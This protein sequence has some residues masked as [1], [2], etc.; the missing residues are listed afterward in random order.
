[1]SHRTLSN[2]FP[3]LASYC[4]NQSSLP[5]QQLSWEKGAYICRSGETMDQLIFLCR[6]EARV[7]MTLYSGSDVLFRIYQP[8]ELFGDVEFFADTSASISVRCMSSCMAYAMP[9]EQLRRER[10]SHPD[11][12]FA[13]A[14][15]ISR[16]LVQSSRS[17]AVHSSYTLKS[18][19]AAF[20][21]ERKEELDVIPSIKDL[22]ESFSVSYRHMLRVHAELCR[23]GAIVR[24]SSGYRAAD[25]DCLQDLAAGSFYDSSGYQ[26]S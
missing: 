26:S 15:G 23:I 3:F 22:S 18:R 9:M 16:K 8:G 2:L 12:I 1:M 14:A 6:G 11:L 24:S 25:C 4:E 10:E 20:Y 17:S 7:F 5:L 19:L 21:L 13:L